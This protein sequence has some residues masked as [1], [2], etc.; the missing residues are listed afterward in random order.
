[1]SYTHLDHDLKKLSGN[2][3]AGQLHLGV[4]GFEE[5]LHHHFQD[6]R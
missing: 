6:R 5:G 1:M 3:A 2:P 4:A